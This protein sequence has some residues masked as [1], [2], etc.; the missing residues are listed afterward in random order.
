MNC[1]DCM[2][3]TPMA[4]ADGVHEVCLNP[5]SI[6]VFQAVRENDTCTEWVKDNEGE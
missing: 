5:D 6:K 2:Y 3:F 4:T 1:K